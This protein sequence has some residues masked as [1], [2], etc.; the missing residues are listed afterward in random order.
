MSAG[1]ALHKK[2]STGVD[3]HLQRLNKTLKKN[4]TACPKKTKMPKNKKKQHQSQTMVSKSHD[5]GKNSGAPIPFGPSWASQHTG[6]VELLVQELVPPSSGL[7]QF[8][9]ES[10]GLVS[11]P[12]EFLVGGWPTPLQNM[13]SSVGMMKFPIYRKIKFMFQT[14][15]QIFFGGLE[16]MFLVE[17]TEKYGLVPL[18]A[19]CHPG[20]T[21]RRTLTRVLPKNRNKNRHQSDEFMWD[22][23][24]INLPW[25]PQRGCLTNHPWPSRWDPEGHFNSSNPLLYTGRSNTSME[26][27]IWLT[28]KSWRNIG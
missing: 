28:H 27:E 11:T 23:P 24:A 19:V 4:M 20:T 17:T 2:W 9:C 3:W 25:P 21:F 7:T 18:A 26:V 5:F 12:H 14:T 10:K 13:T 6:A 15:N 8:W 16:M 1:Y 22:S